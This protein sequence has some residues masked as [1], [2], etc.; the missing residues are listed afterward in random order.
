MNVDKA[1]WKILWMFQ[2]LMRKRARIDPVP[3]KGMWV[4]E[5]SLMSMLSLGH[6][7]VIRLSAPL[8]MNSQEEKCVLFFTEFPVTTTALAQ[9]RQST[10]MLIVYK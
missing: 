6:F 3:A 1:V 10:A 8:T 5:E 4:E 7:N 2:D 9:I